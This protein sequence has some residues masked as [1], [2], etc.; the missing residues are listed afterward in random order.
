MLS[1]YGMKVSCCWYGGD[2]KKTKIVEFASDRV[3]K[4]VLRQGVN[5]VFVSVV[6]LG[7]SRYFLLNHR[8]KLSPDGIAVF[9]TSN[10]HRIGVLQ[11]ARIRGG[12]R[13]WQ[14]LFFG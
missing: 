11:V 13:F 2:S 7:W 3:F 8:V 4:L 1:I 14:S 12:W 9:F 6:G 5:P 10:W